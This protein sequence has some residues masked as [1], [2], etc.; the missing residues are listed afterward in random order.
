MDDRKAKHAQGWHEYL[1]SH[2]VTRRDALRLMGR[3]GVGLLAAANAPLLSSG[4]PRRAEAAGAATIVSYAPAGQRWEFPQRGVYPLFQKKFPNITVDFVAEPI[5]DMFPKSLVAMS[6]K[7]DR[8]DVLH[9]DY[10][11]VAQFVAQGALEP[12]DHYLDQDP[13]YKQDLLSDIPPN[14]MDLYR[15]KSAKGGGHLYGLPPDSNCQLQYYRV[16]VLDKAGIKKPATTWEDALAI[17]K[18]ISPSGR[19]VVG[20]TL[21]RGEWSG[22]T[23]ITL[24]RSYGGDWFDKMG[25]GGW[26]PTL[27]SEEGHMAIAM[28]QKLV[29][30]LDPLSLNAAD[31]E[32]NTSM[33]NGSWEYA[34]VEWGGS[35]MN[36]PKFTKFSAEWKVAVVPKGTGPKARYG[37]HMGGL[38]LLIPSYSH[39]KD[40]AWEW[41]KFCCSGD[42][43]DPAIG[44]AWVDNSGQPARASLLREYTSKQPYFS[45]LMES[46]PHA[47]RFLPIPES[48]TLYSTIGVEVT[49]VVAGSKNPEQAL[50][51]MQ[52]EVTEIMTKGG[53]YK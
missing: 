10:N 41:V 34:P 46:L 43:Q 23:F 17:C 29:P 49:A 24:L 22:A 50:K 27:N 18:E 37:P 12:L 13:A 32:A 19:K 25:P 31:D 2:R 48:N 21:K 36:D 30:Y 40:E 53:Y 8:Y 1:Q 7:S 15:D 52:R 51:D 9:D 20:T 28:L 39:H 4:G 14:V 42:K 5:G 16:D 38:G 6:A 35:T 11:F 44:K 33:L 3:A 26:H 47:I 45:G